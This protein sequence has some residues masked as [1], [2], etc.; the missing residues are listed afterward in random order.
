MFY[1][2][3]SM[4]QSTNAQ[5]IKILNITRY[6]TYKKQCLTIQMYRTIN[7]VYYDKI[8]YNSRRLKKLVFLR[9]ELTCVT[10]F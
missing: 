7:V 3:V 2:H 9:A 1:K 6:K 5:F 4:I 10:M 8:E